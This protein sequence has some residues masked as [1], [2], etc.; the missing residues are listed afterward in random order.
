MKAPIYDFVTG[1]KQSG[2]VRFHMPGHKGHG[3]LGIE[4]YDITEITG[5]D[6]LYSPNGIISE[7]EDNTTSLFGTAH[8]YYSTEGST[9]AIK[10]ML[11]IIKTQKRD[12]PPVILAARNAHRAFINAA[13]LLDLSVEW[14]YPTE[15]SHLCECRL[16]GEDIRAAI[17]SCEALPDAVYITTPDYLGNIADVRE[18]AVVCDLYGIPL[19]GDNA[20]GAYLAFLDEPMH[21]IALGAAMCADSAHKTLPVLTGGAYLHIS[22]KYAEF[23]TA[24]RNALSVFASTSPSYLTLASLDCANRYIA[25]ELKDDLKKCKQLITKAKD[26]LAA[27]GYTLTG[28]EPLKLVIKPGG[29]GYTGVALSEILHRGGIECE[30]ADDDYTVL[31]AS[32]HNTAEDFDR[33]TYALLALPSLSPLTASGDGVCLTKPKRALSIR[34][35]V[36]S[37]SEMI[38]A[39]SSLGRICAA[40]TVCCPPAVAV[41]VSGEII[42]ESAIAA[43]KKYNISKV[44]VVK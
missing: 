4:G 13:A 8:T 26:M 23:T 44:S 36:F 34:D 5:A 12:T 42:D 37:P 16:S 9:L 31:M 40:P 32:P 28:D 7:S 15:D 10:A 3:T 35:A 20:H 22:K 41:V 38:S 2:A 1:Y 39:D 17:E 27:A 30:Y 18:I 6:V 14:I 21:P 33:L 11:A 43:F 19:L 25:E 29:K 24:A